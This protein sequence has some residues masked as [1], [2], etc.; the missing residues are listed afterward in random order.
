MGTRGAYR[1]DE[2]VSAWAAERRD[3][4]PGRVP[5]VSRTGRFGDVGHYTQMIWPTTTRVGCGFAGNRDTEYLV[6][7]YS[8]P[9]N[10]VGRPIG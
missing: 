5:N 9:G 10:V 2:M 4:V 1:Y 3:L 6:C 8:P 7:R